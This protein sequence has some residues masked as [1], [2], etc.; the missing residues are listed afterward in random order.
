MAQDWVVL[1]FGGT[2]VAGGPQWATI[3][4]LLRQRQ[5][6]GY[7]VVLVCSAVAGVTNELT[8]LADSPD[9]QQIRQRI[10]ERHRGLSADLGVPEADWLESATQWL[11]RCTADLLK[12]GG[13][14]SRAEL[15]A[16]GEWLSTRIGAAYLRQQSIMVRWED[17][18]K[19]LIAQAEPDLSPA[20]QWLSG[21]CTAAEDTDLRARWNELDTHVITQGYIA[22]TIDGRT[23]LLG[24][25]GSDTSAALI[26]GRLCAR[27]VE[28]WTDVPGLFSADPRLVAE[29]RLLA[30]LNYAE[31]LEMAA[32]G[33]KVV[34]AQCIRAAAATATPVIIRAA[35]Q[36]YLQGTRI[37][38]GP[39]G[40]LGV[41]A[42]TCQHGMVVLL[43]Q[44]R[45]A[46]REVGFLAGVFATFHRHGVSIDGVATS[47]T[48]TTVA[49]NAPANHL[50][51]AAMDALIADLATQC[52]VT[53]YANCVCIN[54]VGSS[55][56]TCLG[57]L[58]AALAFFDA[59]PLL[60]LSQSA[61]DLCLSMLLEAGG[62]E[63][64]LQAAHQALIPPPG[65]DSSPVFG[66]C[67]SELAGA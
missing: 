56:R 35:R 50:D 53:V 49:L 8:A 19:V 37:G 36:P 38:P 62:H 25:G 4:A 21:S 14:A 60:M 3:A 52:T 41:K 61:N 40:Y 12:G 11:D 17:A 66:Q 57:R 6:Q 55:V 10:I 28:I 13:F 63:A 31:A 67:W 43:L 45:D 42:I 33:A 48:T 64:L 9:C 20:R 44:K 47:E 24:R 23:A 32:S 30:R 39:A 7:R 29:A 27:W 65:D 34:H 22:G 18:R 26:A 58:Q 1:K 2:S 46:R 5:A 59:H 51:R 15:L 16:A 54:L